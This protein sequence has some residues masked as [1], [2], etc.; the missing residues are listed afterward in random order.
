[1]TR[2]DARLSLLLMAGMMIICASSCDDPS[3][4]VARE[5]AQR[6]AQQ[7]DEMARV[8]RDAA[9]ATRELIQEQGEARRDVAQQRGELNTGRDELEHER[10]EI[11][12]SRRTE[13]ALAVLAPG[14]A[15][16]A[17]TLLALGIA[18]LTLFGIA[19][20]DADSSE[21]A[22]ELL[23]TDWAAAE[24]QLLLPS[25]QQS[26]PQL[27]VAAASPDQPGES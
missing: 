13:S 3:A 22:C 5:A 12:A 8:T 25:D 16:I 27:T 17:V 26:P 21:Q 7:N 20:G 24:P 10:R 2:I 23:L 14:A 15:A 18:W 9:H 11:A 1:M 19:R 4:R 6:Q